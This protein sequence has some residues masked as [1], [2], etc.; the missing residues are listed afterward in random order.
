MSR[1]EGILD[2]HWFPE[3]TDLAVSVFVGADLF[4]VT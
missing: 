3:D 2:R 4:H 1:E